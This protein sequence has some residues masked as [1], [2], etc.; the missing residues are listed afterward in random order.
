VMAWLE[1]SILR[2]VSQRRMNKREDVSS[3]INLE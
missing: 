2:L 1:F 3:K